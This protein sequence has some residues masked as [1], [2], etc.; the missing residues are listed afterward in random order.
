MMPC[1][2]MIEDWSAIV[3]MLHLLDDDDVDGSDSSGNRP[4]PTF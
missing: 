1:I 2:M 3:A 4:V